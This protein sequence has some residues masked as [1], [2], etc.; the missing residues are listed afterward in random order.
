MK[1][2][3]SLKWFLV[4]SLAVLAVILVIGYSFLSA[5]FFVR[6]MDNIIAAN[7]DQVVKSYVQAIPSA[8]R[9]K[10]SSFSGYRIAG[11]WDQMPGT[12]R[13]AFNKPKQEKVLLKHAPSGW[14][15]PPDAVHFLMRI[16][17]A[18]ETFFISRTE[19][20]ETASA[21]VGRNAAQSMHLLLVISC[22]SVSTLAVFIWLLL[23]QVERPVKA[24]GQW[25]QKLDEKGL[26]EKP[27][28]FS[29]PE[30]N[31][32]ADL[33]R[34]SL[35]SVQESLDREYRFL[36]HSSHELRTPISVIR[37]NV[38]LLH[39]LQQYNGNKHTPR[40]Q[41]IIGRID[42]ASLTMKHL[43]ETLLWLSR[44]AEESLPVKEFNLEGLVLELIEE[45]QYLLNDKEV[46]IVVRTASYTVSVP[47]APARIVLGN[48]IRNA[49]QHTCG[50]I[51][52]TQEKGCV[53]LVNDRTVANE[54]DRDL[55]FGLGLRLTEQ[56]CR[57][58]NW[59][60]SSMSDTDNYYAQVCL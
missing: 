47:E 38:E 24:L 15:C 34:T 36:R 42:R 29:Y 37:S 31:Q 16:T 33:I 25:A 54:T 17:H 3:I 59:S 50:C 56:L 12:I 49:F 32:L 58:L 28:D 9:Q 7:M 22:I 30:L 4:L 20:R 19:T 57:R 2:H 5:H 45:A 10:A 48:L 23:R 39:K 21:L 53:E 46:D 44:E 8:Q 27:P 60:Y 43:T 55:G 52:I 6:G 14:L 11:N 41:K 26:Q 1:R 35:A 51:F 13:Q 18:G 40:Q